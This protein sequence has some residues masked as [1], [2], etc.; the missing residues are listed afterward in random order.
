MNI[1]QYLTPTL[2]GFE[3]FKYWIFANITHHLNF[4]E[5]HK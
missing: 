4:A 3:M 1:K 5:E 2:S